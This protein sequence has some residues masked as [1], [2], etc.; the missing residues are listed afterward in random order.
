MK[1]KRAQRSEITQEVRN[2]WDAHQAK[3]DHP[4]QPLLKGLTSKY[5]LKL[6]QEAQ[7]KACEELVGHSLVTHWSLVGHSLV[8]AFKCPIAVVICAHMCVF[9][10]LLAVACSNGPIAVVSKFTVM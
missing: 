3:Q 2:E 4:R 10:H 6:F 7:S 8:V 9:V 5:D 1:S